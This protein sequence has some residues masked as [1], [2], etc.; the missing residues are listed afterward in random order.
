MKIGAIL[1]SLAVTLPALASTYT[2]VKSS[3]PEGYRAR[4]ILMYE[5]KN[6]VG[7]IDQLSHLYMMED[8]KKY[9][10]DADF[11]IALSN[12]ERGDAYCVE[13]FKKFIANYP[14]SIRVPYAWA[15]IGD[16]YFFNGKYGEALTAYAQIVPSAFNN[17]YKLDLTY[18]S[19]YSMLKLGEFDRA[20]E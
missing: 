1:L 9:V 10:E 16:C 11:Y 8:G 17:D 5:N 19:A 4:G 13:M 18:R 6:Y 14:A 15:K 20:K 3:S 2:G 12:Y 7:A